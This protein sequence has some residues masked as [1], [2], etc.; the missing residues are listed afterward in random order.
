MDI[1][2]DKIK[3]TLKT[4]LNFAKNEYEHFDKEGLERL[5]LIQAGKI[6]ILEELLE[7]LEK[8]RW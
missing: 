8:G 7:E 4:K 3:V 2:I 6:G 1:D 5:C